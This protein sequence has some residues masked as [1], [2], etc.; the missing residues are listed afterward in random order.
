[1]GC[2]ILDDLGVPGFHLGQISCL[3]GDGFGYNVDD[4]KHPTTCQHPAIDTN[5]NLTT[6]RLTIYFTR[7]L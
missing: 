7:K 6:P 3:L 4:Y 1:M 5:Q 2:E